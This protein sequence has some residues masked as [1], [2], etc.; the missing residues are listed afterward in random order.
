MNATPDSQK[1]STAVRA[2]QNW[3]LWT[4][5]DMVEMRKGIDLGLSRERSMEL[6]IQDGVWKL[7]AGN[8]A[9]ARASL[10]EALKID[11]SEVRALS[12]LSM[13]YVA[14]KQNALALQKVKEYASSQPKSAPVQEFL[15]KV[16]MSSGDRAQARAAFEASK[17]AD[18]RFVARRYR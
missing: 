15:G 10:E 17:M 16:L 18:A 14:Q 13:T 9:G 1:N 7:R 3:V 4:S 2:Q 12:A 8:P 11:S 5:G 6:L